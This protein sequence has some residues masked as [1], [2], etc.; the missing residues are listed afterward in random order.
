MGRGNYLQLSYIKRECHKDMYLE[1]HGHRWLQ[2]SECDYN[3]IRRHL[4]RNDNSLI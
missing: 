1:M 3:V 2:A 4:L